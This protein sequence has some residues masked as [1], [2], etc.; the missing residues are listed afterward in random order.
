MEFRSQ[1]FSCIIPLFLLLVA[2]EVGLAAVA[3]N[4]Y[5][6]PAPAACWEAI[7]GEACEDTACDASCKKV[8]GFPRGG[9]CRKLESSGT[10]KLI[11]H[12]QDERRQHWQPVLVAPA[13][14]DE[15]C[16]VSCKQNKY[17]LGGKCETVGGGAPLCKCQK[18]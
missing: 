13:C 14:A 15:T 5:N 17:R 6:T 7:P 16:A 1:A 4:G 11:C 3:N 18:C 8:Y 12:C 9:Q 10:Q 2:A